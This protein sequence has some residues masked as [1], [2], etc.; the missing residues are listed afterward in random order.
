MSRYNFFQRIAHCIE[1]GKMVIL[2]YCR[3]FAKAYERIY[4][5]SQHSNTPK[6]VFCD[7]CELNLSK[8]WDL[9]FYAFLLNT[10][11][12]SIKTKYVNCKAVI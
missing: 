10:L 2:L 4:L 6:K 3:T 7:I 5:I 11:L 8:L 1:G 9:D 12:L